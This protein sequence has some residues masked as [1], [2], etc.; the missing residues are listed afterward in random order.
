MKRLNEAS[1]NNFFERVPAGRILSRLSKDLSTID[2]GIG[3][4]FAGVPMN[5]GRM[6]VN[7]GLF[8]SLT[9]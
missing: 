4:D 8:Y 3:L 1:I 5:I 2:D 7:F 9:N 6:I